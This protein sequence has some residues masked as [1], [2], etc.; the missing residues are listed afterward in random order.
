MELKPRISLPA[1]PVQA[2]PPARLVCHWPQGQTFQALPP[3]ALA[4]SSDEA[5]QGEEVTMKYTCLMLRYDSDRSWRFCQIA[6]RVMIRWHRGGPA[7]VSSTGQ[8]S[9]ADH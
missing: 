5:P 2:A 8:K 6:Q 7:A 9:V 1:L 3:W 4:L